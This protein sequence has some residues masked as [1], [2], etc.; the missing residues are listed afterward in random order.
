V[1][2][3]VSADYLEDAVTIAGWQAKTGKVPYAMEWIEGE[4]AQEPFDPAGNII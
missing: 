3:G 4:K 1:R 2:T